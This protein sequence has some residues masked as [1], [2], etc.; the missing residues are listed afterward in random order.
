MTHFFNWLPGRKARGGVRDLAREEGTQLR[1]GH[2]SSGSD[3]QEAPGNSVFLP[4][5]DRLSDQRLKVISPSEMPGGH[6][7]AG[8]LSDALIMMV[9][10]E[11]LNIE[12]TQAFLEDAGYRHFVS[13]H[14]PETA[15]ARMREKPPSVLLLDL[16]MPKVD[17]MEIL[18]AMR[19][20]P[21]LR[22]VPV[23]V[24]TITTDANVKLQALSAGAMDFLS[25]PVDPSE[26]ALRIRN[27]LA[28]TAYRDFLTYHDQATGLP[29]KLR[30]TQALKERLE[31]VAGQ[32][33]R[34]ALLHV[35]VDGLAPINAA[36][37]R[38]AGDQVLKRIAKR[39]ASC[40]ETEAGGELSNE[41]GNPTLY[42]FDG[43]EFA[44]LVPHLT[45]VETAAA[46]IS[47]LLEATA[48][49]F[50][51]GS[52]QEIYVTCSIGVA[53]FPNDGRDPDVLMSNAGLAMRHAKESGR[54]A[55]EFFSRELN[56][57][58]VSKLSLGADLRGAF[59]REELELLYLAR[60]DVASGRLVGAES[61]VRWTPAKGPMLEGDSLLELAATSE[62]SQALADWVFE[63]MLQHTRVWRTA[64]YEV[65]PIGVN[66]SL[67]Q[68][69][70]AQMMD[71]IRSAIK[72]GL[73][74]EFL[75]LE[76]HEASTLNPR[77][78]DVESFVKLKKMGVTLA[79]DHFGAG[80]SSLIQLRRFPIDEVKVAPLFFDRIED[81]PDNAA[82]VTAMMAMVRSLGLNFVATGISCAQQLEFLKAQGCDQC[83]GKLFN[84]PMGAIDFA[85]AW[86]PRKR[87][88]ATAATPAA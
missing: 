20:D 49:S 27:T 73:R 4:G 46:F 34:G 22:H 23:I 71:S 51:R 33:A 1:K 3:S 74:P 40:V 28:A 86:L 7:S 68:L 24:L 79:L 76:L 15:I 39:L 56:E 58:A 32:G 2:V 8:R 17:G 62:V 57:R 29:N 10:D 85:S 38:A 42:R 31:V 70:V 84:A 16:S 55:C 53:V 21:V 59:A 75:C 77:R 18:Q 12:M 41:T 6:S 5:E 83:Q 52:E 35:G 54:Q 11:L 80:H 81:N 67:K 61:V 25:K 13:T 64:G 44:I 14:E 66:V 19:D 45:D 26:L 87:E 43:D 50:N 78:E 69:P 37:G 63:Q 36:L 30:Y 9:D 47:K 48:T 60:V 72:A 65:V 88:A 82:I